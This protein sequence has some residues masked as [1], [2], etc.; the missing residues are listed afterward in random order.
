MTRWI[1]LWVLWLASVSVSAATGDDHPSLRRQESQTARTSLSQTSS[2]EQEIEDATRLLES[3][4]VTG[5]CHPWSQEY[6][7][8]L[9]LC[10]IVPSP[11]RRGLLVE[12]VEE[13]TWIIVKDAML[14][15][16]CGLV[17]ALGAGLTM[18]L[19]SPDCGVRLT[20]TDMMIHIIVCF[21][22]LSY[23]DNTGYSL[24]VPVLVGLSTVHRE[25]RWTVEHTRTA[26][27]TYLNY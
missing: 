16:V 6:A 20:R 22:T 10:G 2:L 9:P 18:G 24:H 11:P 15:C 4:G 3:V 14:G 21:T 1:T 7:P 26:R 23:S 27:M 25:L 17:A 5:L 12:L 8:L 19:L 13:D